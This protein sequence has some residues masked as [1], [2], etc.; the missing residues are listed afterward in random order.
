MEEKW[1]KVAENKRSE[2]YVSSLGRCKK[3]VKATG[4]EGISFGSL[5]VKLRYYQFAD[6]YVHRHVAKSFVPNPENKQYVD[7]INSNTCDN[8]AE[9]LRW[10]DKQENNSTEHSKLMRSVNA[11]LTNHKDEI[12]KATKD[13]QCKYFKNGKACANGLCVSS[14]LVYNCLTGNGCCCRAKGWTLKWISKQCNEA[15]QFV[16]ELQRAKAEKQLARQKELD[17]KRVAN[18]AITKAK[19]EARRQ[20]KLEKI[21]QFRRQKRQLK[22]QMKI[23]KI[24]KRIALWENH[25]NYSKDKEKIEKKIQQLKDEKSSFGEK[26]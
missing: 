6:D 25:L 10:V 5:N 4:Q 18:K 1:Q 22:I 2:Y 21:N 26:K 16:Q 14:T 17:E 7:H 9:N 11:W 12:I 13:G 23:A 8:R 20:E 3:I 24:E 19:R 15:Q